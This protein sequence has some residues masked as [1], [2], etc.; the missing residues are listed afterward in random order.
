MP[1]LSVIIP[2]YNAE[3]FLSEA[4]LSVLKQPCKD[5]EIIII[6]DGSKDNSGKI[7]DQLAKEYDCIRVLHIQNQGA[8][9]ARNYGIEVACGKYIAFL[10]ADDVWCRDV[11]TEELREVFL[12][13]KQDIICFGY[14]KTDEKFTFG[15]AYPSANRLVDRSSADY[16]QVASNQSFCAYVYRK[17]L[18]D[19]VKFPVGVRFGE[20][21]AFLF[22][23]TRSANS[24]LMVDK[25]L[26]MYR[27]N[28]NSVM[29]SVSDF[30]YALGEIDGWY[31]AKKCALTD[32][33][34]LECDAMI[35]RRMYKYLSLSCKNGKSYKKL[36]RDMQACKPYQEALKTY[37]RYNVPES[38]VAFINQFTQ[39]PKKT[40]RL[41]RKQ[42][43]WHYTI[44]TLM[45][46]TFLKTLYFR[47]KY[48]VN[49]EDYRVKA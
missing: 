9:V 17:K 27:T 30:D 44:R 12:T 22:L 48:K 18:F 25:Y 36:Y 47:L 23:I 15:E 35:Y 6:N 1:T 46:K 45:R 14:F 2:V 28:R 39:N 13:E 38:N 7:A 8:S 4:V 11:Y 34:R 16:N 43:F 33:D 49:M 41:M 42:G 19:Y 5:V 24:I 29:N 3:K 31:G 37:G 32:Q 40:C 26:F 20:D 10:D 21:I